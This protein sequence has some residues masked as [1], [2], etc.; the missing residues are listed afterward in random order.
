MT[1]WLL[2]SSRQQR[3]NNRRIVLVGKK[4]AIPVQRLPHAREHKGVGT[5]IRHDSRPTT[6]LVQD[7]IA[8]VPCVF[9]FRFYVAYFL[10]VELSFQLDGPTTLV[11]LHDHAPVPNCN[12]RADEKATLTARASCVYK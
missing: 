6:E 8:N 11:Y 12:S 3:A 1:T 5:S 9:Y 4:G 7:G 2:F 10:W